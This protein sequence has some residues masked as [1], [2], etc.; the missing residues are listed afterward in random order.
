MPIQK[1]P[2][3]K[4]VRMRNKRKYKMIKNKGAERGRIICEIHTYYSAIV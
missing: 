4:I 1:Y 2:K 3:L